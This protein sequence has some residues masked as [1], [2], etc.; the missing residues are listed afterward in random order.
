M[1]D[2]LCDLM[3]EKPELPK[4]FAFLT[5][6]GLTE[7]FIGV[8]LKHLD[9]SQVSAGSLVNYLD[10]SLPYIFK[11][12]FLHEDHLLQFGNLCKKIEN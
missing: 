10:K 2:L 1:L 3:E 5:L 12:A 6:A 11:Q 4:N 9:F 8:A 7:C